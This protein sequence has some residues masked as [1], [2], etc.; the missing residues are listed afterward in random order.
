MTPRGVLVALILT[1]TAA[2]VVGVSLER[3][4]THNETAETPAQRVAEGNGATTSTARNETNAHTE[5]GGSESHKGRESANSGESGESGNSGDS[6]ESAN[7]GESG[8]SGK[9]GES[10][11]H[12]QS[13]A[14]TGTRTSSGKSPTEAPGHP[15]ASETL[16]GVNPESSGLLAVAVA[17][18]L[19][20]AAG[21][22][23][24]SASPLV[25]GVVA[26]AMAAFGALDIREVIHQ[27]DESRTGLMLLAALV[28]IL[29]FAAALLAARAAVAT[30]RAEPRPPVSAT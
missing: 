25:L 30:R 6:G 12:N 3:H 14:P 18:S 4:E 7:S 16:L 8:E 29:H 9:S 28:A 27:A 11:E 19:L 26:L 13:T 1:A 20:L 17:V 21:A 2:F 15:E 24:L 5:Q 22:W 10:G 23:W